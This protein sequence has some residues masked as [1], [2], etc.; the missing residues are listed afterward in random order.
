MS[1]PL[2]GEVAAAML[3]LCRLGAMLMLFPTFSE[4]AIPGPARIFLAVGFAAAL[5]PAL[6]GWVE[7]AVRGA[8]DVTLAMLAMG[9]VATGLALGMCVRLMFQAAAMAGAIASHQ[10]GLS[11]A[12]IFDP[13]QGGQA[14]L[15]SRVA[16]LGAALASFAAGIPQQLVAAMMASYRLFP[17]GGAFAAGDWAQLAVGTAGEAMLLAVSLA[18]PFILF[19][20]LFNLMLGLVARLAPNLQIFFIAQPAQL[21]I[22]LLLLASSMGA[23]LLG[24]ADRFADWLGRLGG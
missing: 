3:L 20:L 19:G 10:I 13:A 21:G 8:G 2:A 22:G 5:S 11:S 1:L 24:F 14:P 17:V 4:D 18:A 15:L 9:E 6:A 23:M 12:I 16:A 7:P